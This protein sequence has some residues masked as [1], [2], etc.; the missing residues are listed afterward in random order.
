MT[1]RGIKTLPYRMRGHNN[2]A[3]Q[4]AG[5]LNSHPAVA[6]VF[7]PGLK[8]H[9]FHEVAKNQMKA[10][11]GMLSFMVKG[12]SD[13]ARRISNKLKL[14]TRATSLGGVESLIEHRASME[15]PDTKTPANLLRISVGLEYVEDL[16]A[17]LEQAL[18]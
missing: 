6:D 9:P 13:D 10:F 8:T 16:I 14:I 11:G 3:M 1:V 15:G 12:G 18:K 4:I 2:N 17:D 5:Y 7:Y